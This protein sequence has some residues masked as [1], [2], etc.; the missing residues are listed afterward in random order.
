MNAQPISYNSGTY[1]YDYSTGMGQV[2]G[3]A[4]G[5]KEITPGVWGMRSGDGDG[6]GCV[7]ALDKTNVWKVSS[8]NG[9]AGYL[10]SDFNM[11]RQTNNKDK[12]DKWVPNINTYSQVP[13]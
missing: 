2:Y 13:D 8:Q 7:T 5:H 1:T 3:G 12:N 4:A 6:D 11:D 10:P 9:K